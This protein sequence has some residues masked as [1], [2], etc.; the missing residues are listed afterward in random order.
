MSSRIQEHEKKPYSCLV[1]EDVQK[2]HKGFHPEHLNCSHY[3]WVH[4]SSSGGEGYK[5][6]TRMSFD[7]NPDHVQNL[8]K[9]YDKR[10]G[11]CGVGLKCLM[12]CKRV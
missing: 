9:D 10:N 3:S 5:M 12:P 2:V 8:C 11:N 6:G 4:R 1:I 7:I